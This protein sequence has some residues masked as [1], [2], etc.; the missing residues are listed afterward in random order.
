M[1]LP[2]I[3]APMFIVTRE[4]NAVDAYK[5]MI[6]DSSAADIVYTPYRRRA[7]GA[8]TGRAPAPRVRDCA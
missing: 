2:V 8:R 1:V 5:Q 7:S 4:A 3:G 6:V